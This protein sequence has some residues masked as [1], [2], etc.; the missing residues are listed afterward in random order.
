MN[1]GGNFIKLSAE[2]TDSKIKIAEATVAQTVS[3]KNLV[4]GV[5]SK[6]VNLNIRPQSGQTYPRTL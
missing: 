4:S 1:F 6:T 3:I 2:E 5:I